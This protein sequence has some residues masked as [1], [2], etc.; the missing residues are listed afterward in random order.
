MVVSPPGD[1][2]VPQNLLEKSKT[3]FKTPTPISTSRP[4]TCGQKLLEILNKNDTSD[5]LLRLLDSPKLFNG[6]IWTFVNYTEQEISC[7]ETETPVTH[8][9]RK[10]NAPTNPVCSREK[11]PVP[12]KGNVPPLT[13]DHTPMSNST[14]ATLPCNT[15]HPVHDATPRT[16]VDWRCNDKVRKM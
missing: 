16:A 10:R 6:Q 3:I 2:V 7:W 4:A 14:S 8:P 1:T 15:P 5:P 12:F 11:T 13:A 9:K